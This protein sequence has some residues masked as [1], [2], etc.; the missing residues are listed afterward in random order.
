MGVTSRHWGSLKSTISNK[1]KKNIF[2]LFLLFLAITGNIGW[3]Q[4][5]NRISKLE[6]VFWAKTDSIQEK[7]QVFSDNEKEITKSINQI[8]EVA[9]NTGY[10]LEFIFE[11]VP[12]LKNKGKK[13]QEFLDE[14]N[15]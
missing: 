5:N 15:H 10:V 9:Q 14:K 12:Q 2:S 8:G 7:Q 4:S 11:E 1:M 6:K 3:Y 13:L